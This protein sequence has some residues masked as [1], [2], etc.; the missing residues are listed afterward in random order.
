M[1]T[2]GLRKQAANSVH[3]PPGETQC[4][5]SFLLPLVQN[6]LSE[7]WYELCT[8]TRVGSSTLQLHAHFK[9]VGG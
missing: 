3:L 8:P 4:S 9:L 5:F 6:A 1:V 2:Q 7:I